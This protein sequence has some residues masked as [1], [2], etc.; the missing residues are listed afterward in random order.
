M[1]ALPAQEPHDPPLDGRSAAG[2]VT[3]RGE[4]MLDVSDTWRRGHA[5]TRR[6]ASPCSTAATR[7]QP[8]TAMVAP[9]DRQVNGIGPWISM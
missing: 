8:Q 4:S 1:T 7:R 6:A 5:W 2:V 3:G 9:G